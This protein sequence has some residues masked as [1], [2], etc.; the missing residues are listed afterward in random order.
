MLDLY[1][2]DGV[3]KRGH[4]MN[5][6]NR[7]YGK[8]GMAYCKHATHGGVLIVVY[9]GDMAPEAVGH[10]PMKVDEAFSSFEG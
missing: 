9:A 5:M 7:K 3:R 6:I 8:T 2:D 1:I 10:R 4:R